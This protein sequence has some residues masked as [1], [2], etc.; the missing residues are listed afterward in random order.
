MQAAQKQP[1]LDLD[2][3]QDGPAR[4]LE[5]QSKEQQEAAAEGGETDDASAAI[6]S[7]G[8]PARNR[9]YSERSNRRYQ[10]STMILKRRV[11]QPP[12][13]AALAALAAPLDNQQSSTF[14]DTPTFL[15]L[16]PRRSQRSR[17]FSAN[18]GRQSTSMFLPQRRRTRA[19]NAGQGR[20]EEEEAWAEEADPL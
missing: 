20:R 3:Y 16:G 18:A 13:A 7:R 4:V 19:G 6:P 12:P 1:V 9:Y 11:K 14:F 8:L 17:P 15:P 2:V 10:Y 5:R